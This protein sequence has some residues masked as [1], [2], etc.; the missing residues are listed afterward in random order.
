MVAVQ[1]MYEYVLMRLSRR[2]SVLYCTLYGLV[3]SPCCSVSL[4]G[5]SMKMKASGGAM[6]AHGVVVMYTREGEESKWSEFGIR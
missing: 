5:T 2:G 3:A 4:I 1:F 6:V